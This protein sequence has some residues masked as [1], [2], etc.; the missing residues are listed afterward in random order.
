MSFTV[1]QAVYEGP[2]EV[3]L[4]LIE[5]RKLAISDIS[6]AAVADQFL[7]YI[8]TSEQFPVAQASQFVWVAS[9]LVLIKAKSLL[10]SIEMTTEEETDITVLEERLRQLAAV[11]T[12]ARALESLWG[13]KP[14]FKRQSTLGKISVFSPGPSV[15]IASLQESLNSLVANLQQQKNELENKELVE[16]AVSQTIR[17]EEVIA[18]IEQ[19]ITAGATGL[20]SRITQGV[21]EKRSLIVTFLAL[22]EMARQAKISL[23]QSDTFSDIEFGGYI[24]T[25]FVGLDQ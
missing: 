6:L 16:V 8:T 2:L 3:L 18:R 17:L 25:E 23:V 22:L 4:S 21:T 10:P 15:T 14:L 9:T 13:S 5:E 20:F 24:S 19:T 12:S 11:R 1:H 7:N